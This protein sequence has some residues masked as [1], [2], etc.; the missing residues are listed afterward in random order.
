MSAPDERG[1]LRPRPSLEDEAAARAL[2]R[3]LTRAGTSGVA[4]CS[5]SVSWPG[6]A[7]LRTSRTS[8]RSACSETSWA[9]PWRRSPRP[10]CG[11]LVWLGVR[12]KDRALRSL[13]D[14]LAAADD[15][16]ARARL[17]TVPRSPR[18][19]GPETARRVAEA[20]R[21]ADVLHED[22]VEVPAIC[23]PGRRAGAWNC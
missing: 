22:P 16:A 1:A 6:S 8:G 4:V 17:T 11:A 5:A 23:F 3:R 9:V 21:L 13:V 7:S 12:V 2:G 10:C 15:G 18:A 14:A 20:V 19:V